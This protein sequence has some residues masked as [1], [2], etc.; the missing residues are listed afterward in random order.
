MESEIKI[1]ILED[2]ATDAEL[3][4]NEIKKSL[5]NTRFLIVNNETDF[6]K[7]LQN[8]NPDLIITDLLLP[9]YDGITALKTVKEFS[10]FTP[11]IIFTGSVNEDT[12]VNCMKEGASDYVTKD[13]FRRIG[14]AVIN[15]LKEKKLSIKNYNSEKEIIK[16]N[17]IY[18]LLSN[19]NKIIN[20]V[21]NSQ[22]LF[23]E[24]CRIA[25]DYAKFKFV[26]IVIQNNNK[27]EIKALSSEKGR[28][29]AEFHT[30]FKN[31]QKF[32]CC[33]EKT[34]ESGIHYIVN[35]IENESNELECKHEALR[36][37]FKSSASFP[38]IIF[39]KTIGALNLYSDEIDFFQQQEI[40]L[41]DEMAIDISFAL[42]IIENQ[43][44]HKETI[45]LLKENERRLRLSLMAANQGLYDLNIKTGETVVNDIYATMLGYDPKT[46]KE[47]NSFWIE[48]LHPD[49][50]EPVAKV[51]QD[52]V[53]GKIP[54]YKVEF[55]Q[56]TADGNWKW[57]LSLGKVVEFDSD[58]SPLRMLGTHTDI[59]EK[60]LYEEKL[61]QSDRVFNHASD[62]LCIAGFDGYFKVLNPAWEKTL[63]WSIEELTSKPWI[64]FVHYEDKDITNKVGLNTIRG[65]E[66]HQFE[67]RYICKDGSIRW[68]SWNTHS[69][70]DEKLIYGA[71]RDI[72]K[73]KEIQNEIIESEKKYKYLFE[74]SPQPMWIYDEDT[75][76]ILAVNDT[77][78]SIYG[79]SREEFLNM[80]VLDIR[81]DSEKEKVLNHVT[82]IKDRVQ[83]SGPW[84]HKLKN[85]E[86]IYVTIVS[87]NI[88]FEGKNARM[89][90]ANDVSENYKLQKDLESSEEKFRK[91]FEKHSAI[92][93]ILDP[94]NGNIIDANE[95]AVKFYGWSK[96]EL[97]KMNISQINTLPV[98]EIKIA[99]NKVNNNEK[100]HFEFKHRKANG[101][102]VDVEVFSSKIEIEEKEFI[103]SIVIDI[104]EKKK[105]EKS[106]IENEKRY[107]AVVESLNQAYYEAD[108]KGKFLYCNQGI[109]SIGGFSEE[110]IKTITAFRL[111]AKEDRKRVIEKY[112]NSVLKNISDLSDEFRVEKKDGTKF[113]V[114]QITHIEY[115]NN[116]KLIK[117]SNILRDINERK[118]AE[119]KLLLLNR[120]IEQ[121]SV[122]IVITDPDGFINYVNP[123]FTQ[124]TGYTFEE[125]QGKN[126]KIL[127][128]G[129]QSK[130]F[131]INMW[132]TI[133]S[134]NTWTGQF[135]N[136][137]KN[138]EIFWEDAIISPIVNN[139]NRITNFVAIKE[140]ITELK[141]VRDNLTKTE[142]RFHSV[143]NNASEGMRLVNEHGI[144]IDANK[145]FCKLF[146][147]PAEKI[148]GYPFSK[149]F[150]TTADKNALEIY[151]KKFREDEIELN[152]EKEITLW[153][154]TKKWFSISNSYIKDENNNKL[155]LSI[156]SDITEKKKM[157]LE[158]IEAKEKAEEMNKVKSIFFANMSHELRTPLIGILGFSELLK[159]EFQDNP[160]SLDMINNIY[161]GGNRLLDTLNLILN[162]SKIESDKTEFKLEDKNIVPLIKESIDLYTGIASQNNI[163]II[164]ENNYSD[165]NCPIDEG[166]FNHVFNNIINNAVK[167]TNKGYVKISTE[168]TD[169]KVLIK[170]KDTGIGIPEDKIGLIWEEF[171]QASEGM[172]RSFEGTGLGLTIAKK[173]TELMGGS[174]SVESKVNEG[175]TFTII[176][177]LS[178]TNEIIKTEGKM[179]SNIKLNSENEKKI[180]L[181]Y[182]EDDFIAAKLVKKILPENFILDIA[183]S[184]EEAIE[185][186]NKK[187]YDGFLM[188]INLRKGMDGIMITQLIREKPEYKDTPIIAVTAYA[189]E[190][191]K[192]EFL[193]K[194]MT[195]YI[196]KPFGKKNLLDLISDVFDINKS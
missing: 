57:I 142:F 41:L 156:F 15:A 59:T 166:L 178:H 19:T 1:L 11:V 181:L 106:L 2:L 54:E 8:F 183:E 146:N 173:Y 115:D 171:R 185:K 145:S 130:E 82:K 17:G 50:K 38:I 194:G 169:N 81:P 129:L 168:I 29:L 49:D 68:L 26:W 148:I 108:E 151:K 36:L 105:A 125:V 39:G 78:V 134:G 147:L 94:N 32:K 143:W 131:Y 192:K 112:K 35:N 138:G 86:I 52:Y 65:N 46:F 103:H 119:E 149:L 24:I 14:K 90:I 135:Q 196:S 71:V 4:I 97:K 22:Y 63:G 37:G 126:P 62:M 51:Y 195:H 116:G 139:N 48:R 154:G 141:K 74:H 133:L 102:I 165:I 40:N 3:A 25:R 20:R 160:D 128:S 66:I 121:S 10:P 96:N 124:V 45:E 110:D 92:K 187:I 137:K 190:D 9:S 132:N 177:P 83:N 98:D 64:E 21:K 7:E 18:L 61:L 55:R 152:F 180:N 43:K 53:A 85:G 31:N 70:L 91:L 104:S 69:Y 30:Q 120:T 150:Y 193:E 100:N 76:K 73:E 184:G 58:G 93:Y 111:V 75:L 117:A 5:P 114:E 189:M 79:F 42:E 162:L 175:S 99:L 191:D 56:K 170:V 34:I 127:S 95:A 167:F 33:V 23:S 47:T 77:A 84:K 16:L 60:K 179:D 174:I 28:Q 172:S 144:I 13:Q 140:D 158:I 182:V 164:F 27:I 88:L 161:K 107:R 176:F 80:T 118:L 186:F 155:L 113:W 89:V 44:H 87:H 123:K 6:L 136:K 122:S 157:L 188:D 72:T 163:D 67:N 101:E 153:N 159:E 109:F 12:A